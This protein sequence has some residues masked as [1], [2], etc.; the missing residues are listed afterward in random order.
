MLDSLIEATALPNLH[1]AVVHFP[2]ACLPLAIGFDL[3]GLV[4]VKQRWLTPAA[5]TLYLLGAA[6]AWLAVWAGKQAA[7]SVVGVPPSAQLP[8]STH[9]DWA[10][11]RSTP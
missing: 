6:G 10:T 1:P 2:I 3:A 7:D 11:T 4:A 5:T 8:M 9:S